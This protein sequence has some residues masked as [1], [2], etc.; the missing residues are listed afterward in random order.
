MT[1]NEEIKKIRKELA[2]TK[3]VPEDEVGL[4]INELGSDAIG[5]I[6]DIEHLTNKLQKI[7]AQRLEEA[8]ED[9]EA[10]EKAVFFIS[11]LGCLGI[12]SLLAL[13]PAETRPHIIKIALEDAEVLAQSMKK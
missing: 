11:H 3:G 4:I 6:K 10:G 1:S 12:A 2:K 8:E 13:Y 5:A 9:T 7:F